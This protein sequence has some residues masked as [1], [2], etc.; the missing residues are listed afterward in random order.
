[1][2]HE[3]SY[4]DILQ[5]TVKE[6]T[7]NQPRLQAIKLYPVCDTDSGH[8]LII[9]TGWDK[10]RW[11]DTILFHARLVDRHVII[12]EDNFEEGLT[13][14]LIAAGIQAEHIVTSLDYQSGTSPA[15]FQAV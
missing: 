9:A 11:I 10:Q 5:K 15:V 7:R 2:E 6:A 4:V 1:M 13:S 12:E 14:A 3:I 8:F